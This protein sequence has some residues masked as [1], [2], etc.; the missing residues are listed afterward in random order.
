MKVLRLSTLLIVVLVANIVPHSA[1]GSDNINSGGSVVTTTNNQGHSF[2]Q[3]LLNIYNN[4]RHHF[5]S[6]RD[7]LSNSKT[8]VSKTVGNV[9]NVCYFTTVL[10]F[11]NIQYPL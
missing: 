11:Y 10:D 6:I 8:S 2:G 1:H 5:N 9:V 7:R 3:K 4:N